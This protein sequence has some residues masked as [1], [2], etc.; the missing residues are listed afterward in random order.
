MLKVIWR[1]RTKKC[2]KETL[3]SF[4]EASSNITLNFIGN[5]YILHMKSVKHLSFCSIL[6]SLKFSGVNSISVALSINSSFVVSNLG[7]LS[8]LIRTMYINS[9]E[10]KTQG[11]SIIYI[12]IVEIYTL[13]KS[14][15][16][17]YDE[18][19]NYD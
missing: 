17:N 19:Y 2:I 12:S 18:L 3:T 1:I 10:Y 14:I 13:I 8:C 16:H 9:R 15:F 6:K 4:L 5:I 11:H 7:L